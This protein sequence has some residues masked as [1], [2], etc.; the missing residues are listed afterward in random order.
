MSGRY[1]SVWMSDAIS[2][3]SKPGSP[4]VSH[5]LSELRKR[6]EPWAPPSLRDGHG[7]RLRPCGSGWGGCGWVGMLVDGVV[8]FAKGVESY[9]MCQEIDEVREYRQTW[10]GS[11]LMM[12]GERREKKRTDDWGWH[13]RPEDGTIYIY[14]YI[15]HIYMYTCALYVYM[16]NYM[17]IIMCSFAPACNRI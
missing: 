10:K 9:G 12:G 7:S 1:P 14:I 6:V 16:C 13:G 5:S 4:S 15:Y 8:V 3:A 17:Y 11:S 2:F